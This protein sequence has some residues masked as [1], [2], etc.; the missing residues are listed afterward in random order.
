MIINLPI[1]QAWFTTTDGESIT[2]RRATA[3]G[4]DSITV[5]GEVRQYG[6]RR[7]LIRTRNRTSQIQL[8]LTKITP[9]QLAWLDD[10]AGETLLLRTETWRRWGTYLQFQ[11]TPMYMNVPPERQLYRVTLTWTDVDVDESV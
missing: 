4:V 6:N 10:H 8:P 7:R 5:G 11:P 3:W 1:R 2:P 9:D